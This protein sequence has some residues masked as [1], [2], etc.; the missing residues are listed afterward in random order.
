MNRKL[1]ISVCVL[2]IVVVLF[3][4]NQ[5]QK[6]SMK[7]FV[8]YSKTMSFGMVARA[9]GG[10]VGSGH[11]ALTLYSTGRLVTENVVADDVK[12]NEKKVGDSVVAEVIRMINDSG[13]MTTE[14]PVEHVTDVS[15]SYV[16]ATS[17][18]NA[19]T[20]EFPSCREKLDP[21][22]MYLLK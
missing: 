2:A 22:E 7:E 18:S 20:I 6:S 1:I 9:G 8:V 13:V 11:N 21:I 16:V 15:G 10:P 17:D 4:F 3:I 14:C 19:K 12:N 5:N